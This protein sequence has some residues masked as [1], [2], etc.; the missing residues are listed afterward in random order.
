MSKL[1]VFRKKVI[2]N[3]TRFLIQIV[4]LKFI[5]RVKLTTILINQL[6]TPKIELGNPFDRKLKIISKFIILITN[7]SGPVV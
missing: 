2:G 4:S 1:V 7:S 3:F 5:K 6:I